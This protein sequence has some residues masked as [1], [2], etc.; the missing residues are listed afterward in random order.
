MHPEMT[1]SKGSWGERGSPC[2][3]PT[4]LFL[5]SRE[6]FTAPVARSRRERGSCSPPDPARPPCPLSMDPSD[7]FSS[8][9]FGSQQAHQ[10]TG[11]SLPG[12]ASSEPAAA[13]TALL[14]CTAGS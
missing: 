9:A 5:V 13:C 11:P 2:M 8:Q 4:S 12:P 7:S 6:R 1:S 3:E 10:V 14:H